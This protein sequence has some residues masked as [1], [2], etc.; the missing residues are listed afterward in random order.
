MKKALFTSAMLATIVSANVSAN[1]NYQHIRNATAKIDIAGTTFLVD[2]YLA[3]KGSYAGFEGTV[4]SEKRNPLIELSMPVNKVLQG[5]DAVIVT[6]THDDHW[7]KVAQ[8]L[9]PKSLPIFVQNAG[10]AKIIRGQGFKDVR[11]VGK[12]TTFNKVRLS[13]TGGQHGTDEMYSVPQLAELAGEAMGVVMQAEGEKTLYLIG[14]TIWNYEVDHAL[15][16]YKPDLVV[17][18]TGYA[19]LTGFKNSIIMGTADVA[20]AYKKAPNAQ[21]IT[22]HMD[23]VNHTTISSDQMRKFVKQEKM[24]DRVNVPKEGQTLSFK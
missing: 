12:N 13:K 19:Q 15:D 7:D 16:T 5:V 11:V 6:H 9:L 24:T 1:I 2:P 23:A 3:P 20:K 10:D 22:V 8:Q 4:N 14:D 21:L 17:M 18:N